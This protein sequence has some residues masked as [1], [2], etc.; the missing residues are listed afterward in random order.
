MPEGSCEHA[1]YPAA[2]IKILFS[3]AYLFL[4]IYTLLTQVL[5]LLTLLPHNY[6]SKPNKS[7]T[8]A[9][10]SKNWTQETFTL[11]TVSN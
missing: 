2:R 5:P 1:S 6:P 4:P 8:T 7:H 9:I 11:N 10:M 3:P